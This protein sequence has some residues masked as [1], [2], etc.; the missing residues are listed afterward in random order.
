MKN[1]KRSLPMLIA[2]LSAVSLSAVG[3]ST[4]I[5]SYEGKTSGFGT[6]VSCSSAYAQTAVFKVKMTTP[7]VEQ[8]KGL[9]KRPL[10]ANG[11]DTIDN[12]IHL[13]ENIELPAPNDTTFGIYADEGETDLTITI[14]AT[15]ELSESYIKYKG[16]PTL[17]H[18]DFDA[19][20][21]N[22]FA[23]NINKVNR[24]SKESWNYLNLPEDTLIDATSYKDDIL[25]LTDESNPIVTTKGWT[26]SKQANKPLYDINRVITLNFTWGDYFNNQTPATYY[27][28]VLDAKKLA[29]GEKGLSSSEVYQYF[30]NV[31]SELQAM[32]NKCNVKSSMKDKASLALIA[33]VT[34]PN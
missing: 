33:T 7:Q 13:G 6:Q 30:D 5:F 14:D 15:V 8:V 32:Y 19:S 23:T 28:D 2:A 11:A 1:R 12:T 16:L 4:W 25:K 34:L 9:N 26:I 29:A 24:S 21:T 3:F 17:I 22:F 20:S 31:Q 27:N 18:Y 10:K